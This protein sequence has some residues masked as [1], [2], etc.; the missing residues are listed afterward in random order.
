[1]GCVF[2]LVHGFGSRLFVLVKYDGATAQ[3]GN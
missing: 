2:P 3:S 1:M